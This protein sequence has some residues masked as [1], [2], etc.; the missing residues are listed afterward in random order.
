MAGRLT[1]ELP[2]LKG[3]DVEDLSKEAWDVLYGSVRDAV[4]AAIK[5]R[6][7]K[8]FGVPDAHELADDEIAELVTRRNLGHGVAN[9][10][11][12]AAWL[13]RCTWHG[14]LDRLRVKSRPRGESVFKDKRPGDRQDISLEQFKK[15]MPDRKHEVEEALRLSLDDMG[16]IEDQRAVDIFRESVDDPRLT[17]AQLKEQ[18]K[19]G[20]ER[21][22]AR[23]L[24]VGRICTAR[25]MG[26]SAYEIERLCKV[27]HAEVDRVLKLLDK[28][29]PLPRR[30]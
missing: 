26:C 25:R 1:E 22:V 17:K 10:E 21:T 16:R 23:Y 7:P 8:V 20:T 27:E 13:I 28:A 19:V 15:A 18:Y 6:D 4:V 5:K 29:A 9:R 14:I 30:K 2:K 3:L 11:G 12:V 24:R